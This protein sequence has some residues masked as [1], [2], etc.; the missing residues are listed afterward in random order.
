MTSVAYGI[1]MPVS[2]GVLSPPGFC[3]QSL[4][5]FARLATQPTL[6]RKTLYNSMIAS[7]VSAGVWGKLDAL[8]M[9]AAADQATALTNLVSPNFGATAVNSPAFTADHG[10]SGNGTSAYI[11]TNFNPVSAG[12]QYALNSAH[13]SCW[14]LTAQNSGQTVAGAYD[15]AN[16][17]Y[18]TVHDGGTADFAANSATSSIYSP[19]TSGTPGFVLGSRT[20]LNTIAIYKNN[21]MLGSNSAKPSSAIPNLPIYIGGRNNSGAFG[22]GITDQIASFSAGAGLTSADALALYNAQ[23]AYM[24][25]VAGVA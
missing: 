9:F 17:S 16:I 4:A 25:A 24:Q 14:D 6:A 20:D 19:A 2:R 8:Y 18:L 23:H 12:G 3:A 21:S 10:I 5:F 22:N 15:G 11:N 7:L 13:L 1:A